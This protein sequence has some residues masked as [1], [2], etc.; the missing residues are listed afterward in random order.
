MD[1][2]AVESCRHILLSDITEKSEFS[3]VLRSDYEAVAT[4]WQWLYLYVILTA[5]LYFNTRQSPPHL[6]PPSLPPEQLQMTNSGFV[7]GAD[8]LCSFFTSSTAVMIPLS[9]RSAAQ[10][11]SLRAVQRQASVQT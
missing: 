11:V 2:T 3:L 9:K 10:G 8:F 6:P 4:L 5:A 7:V 1:V